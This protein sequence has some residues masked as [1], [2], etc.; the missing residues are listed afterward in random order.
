MRNKL[1]TLFIALG[2]FSNVSAYDVVI[3]NIYY[4]L[5]KTTKTAEVTYNRLH[6]M[7]DY[8]GDI[9]IPSTIVDS[10]ETYTVTGVGTKAFYFPKDMKSI[11]LASTLLYIREEAFWSCD[12]LTSIDIPKSVESIAVYAFRSSS[13]SCINVDSENTK[14]TSIDGILYCKDASTLERYPSGLTA[15]HFSIPETVTKIAPLAFKDCNHLITVTIPDRVTEIGDEA[16]QNCSYLESVNIPSGLSRIGSCVFW[17]SYLKSISIPNSVTSIGDNAFAHSRLTTI[18]IPESVTSIGDKA[19]WNCID[20]TSA[21]L[22]KSVVSLG[23]SL[24]LGCKKLSTISVDSENPSYTSI[25]GILYDKTISTLICYPEGKNDTELIIP[26]TV[27]V[28]CD[29]TFQN[30]TKL[31]NIVFPESLKTIGDYAFYGCTGLRTV[32]LPRSLSKL[33]KAS[34]KD[35]K[36]ITKINIKYLG[37]VYPI[38]TGT[39]NAPFDGV[40]I[41]SCWITVPAG[42]KSKYESMPYWKFFKHYIGEYYL[43]KNAGANTY[44]EPSPTT[45]TVWGKCLEND[46]KI[47]EMGFEGYKGVTTLELKSLEPSKDN[48]IVFYAISQEGYK[49]TKEVTFTQPKLVLTT[50]Q[51]KGV[52]STCSIVAATTNISE[53]E[54]NVGFQWKK[55]DA[56]ATISPKEG[57]AVIHEGQIEGRINNLQTTS[58]YDVRAFYKSAAGNYYYGDWVTFDPSDFSYFEPTLHTYE[59][60]DISSN[61]ATIKAYILAGTDDIIE[62]GF[63]YWSSFGNGARTMRANRSA[64]TDNS[65]FTVI[66]SGQLM[67]VTLTDL[68]PNSSYSYR[69]YIKTAAGTAYGEEKSFITGNA[70]T[71][72]EDVERND[73]KLVVKGYYDISGKKHEE[74]QQGLNIIR[75]SD[76]SAKKIIVK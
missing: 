47:K 3:D 2:T 20:M 31:S 41:T 46:I 9:V 50:L 34:F 68:I 29:S 60:V 64:T 55:Y 43:I 52:S 1:F 26:S 74:P 10:G 73:S 48:S 5:D 7:Y 70:T 39:D 45:R 32:S 27:E 17:G 75:Y 11:V 4:N 61:S 36:N 25:E 72:I 28:I 58:Y 56:P 8:S 42:L 15:D 22:P 33:G 49:E 53:V 62:Q 23:R 37:R 14:Y 13:L 21:E 51:P 19:F 65:V 35:C 54:T 38:E 44:P 57:L 12:D 6:N 63:E 24:F 69:S 67:I 66:G 76:G 16:F 71:E 18:S 40:S 30:C 59:A